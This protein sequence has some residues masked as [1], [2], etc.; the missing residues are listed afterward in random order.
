MAD[1]GP[2]KADAWSPYIPGSAKLTA[3]WTYPWVCGNCTEP[4][5]GAYAKLNRTAPSPCPWQPWAGRPYRVAGDA[6]DQQSPDESVLSG[7]CHAVFMLI[8]LQPAAR[9]G[10]SSPTA[11]R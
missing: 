8:G 2:I 6:L 3:D 10:H 5:F 7:A 11:G 9:A 4:K 1:Q